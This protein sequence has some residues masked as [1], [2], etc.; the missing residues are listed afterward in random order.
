[1]DN[2]K[3]TLVIVVGIANH[4]SPRRFALRPQF[5]FII[6]AVSCELRD[7]LTMNYIWS[8]LIITFRAGLYQT[9][10]YALRPIFR[11]NYPYDIPH[12]FA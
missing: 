6:R 7:A 4:T 12:A 11:Y 2:L 10:N 5:E 3:Y 1:M 9:T 8:L